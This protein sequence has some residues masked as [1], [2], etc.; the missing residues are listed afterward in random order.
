LGYRGILMRVLKLRWE[1][2]AGGSGQSPGPRGG[3]LAGD[4]ETVIP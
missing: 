4:T 1:L 3:A 2:I